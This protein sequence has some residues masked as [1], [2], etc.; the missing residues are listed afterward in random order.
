MWEVGSVS[1]DEDAEGGSK[2]QPGKPPG[3]GEGSGRG[4]GERRGLL[5]EDEMDGDIDGDKGKMGYDRRS[6][7]DEDFGEYEAVGKSS[8]DDTSGP[9]LET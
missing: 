1:D 7:D 4:Q 6:E 5:D 2:E 3:L 9:G 8:I